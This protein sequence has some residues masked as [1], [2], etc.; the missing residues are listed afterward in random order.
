M[1]KIE[2]KAKKILL[3]AAG[4]KK[5]QDE[6]VER[7]EKLKALR[8]EKSLAYTA[9]GDTWHDNPYFNELEQKEGGLLKK[10][11][12]LQNDISNAIIFDTVSRNTESVM[13]GSI[14]KCSLLFKSGK[15]EKRVFEV[16]GYQETNVRANKLSYT[17]PIARAILGKKI[18]DEVLVKIPSGSANMVVEGLYGSWE[19]Y[20]G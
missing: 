5:L 14:V 17:A 10:I 8:K 4:L 6:L 3:T 16:V 1:A 15:E 7:S 18:D 9:T 19:E 11:I 20:T 2:D 13:L 12:E